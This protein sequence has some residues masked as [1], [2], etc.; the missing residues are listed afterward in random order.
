TFPVLLQFGDEGFNFPDL[1]PS[2]QKQ[3]N[4]ELNELTSKNVQVRLID[5]LQNGTTLNK[6]DVFTVELL[7]S[8]DNSAAL[9]SIELKAY[10]YYTL[11]SIHSNDLPYYITQ[12]I[13]FHLLQ[14]ELTL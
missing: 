3:V 13:L 9:D 11:K 7:H 6:K 10:V 12:V 8:T 1:V 5:N 14:P 4:S 2:V